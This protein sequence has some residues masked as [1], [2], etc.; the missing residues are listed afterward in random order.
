MNGCFIFTDIHPAKVSKMRNEIVMRKHIFDNGI[1][2]KVQVPVAEITFNFLS[3]YFIWGI[4]WSLRAGWVQN[5]ERRPKTQKR[6][7][8][9]NRFEIT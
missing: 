6:R 2:D 1:F 5:E 3:A 9:Q 8:R 4:E 7:P